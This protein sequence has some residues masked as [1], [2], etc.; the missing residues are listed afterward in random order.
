MKAEIFEFLIRLSLTWGALLAFYQWAFSGNDN[1]RLKRTFLLVVYL[2]GWMIPLLPTLYA[3]ST[4]PELT[5]RAGELVKMVGAASA[6]EVAQTGAYH[7]DIFKTIFTIYLTG[8]FW[9]SIK[10][11]MQYLRLLYWK[12]TGRQSTFRSFSVI[13]H[14]KIATP[15]A[16]LSTIFLPEKTDPSTI[17]M[18][19]LHE[20]VHL[21]SKH[22]IE[23]MPLILG[24]VFLWFHPLQWL[25]LR[26]QE[27]IQEYE[28][29]E[30][31]TREFSTV[32][33]GKLLIQSSMLSSTWHPKLFSSP[34]K[35]R[36]HMMTKQKN[37]KRLNKS[38]YLIFFALLGFLL[39]NCSD[40]V[41]QVDLTETTELS[42]TEVDQ[43]PV[44]QLA[45]A[46]EGET[47]PERILL[48]NIYREITYPASARSAGVGGTYKATF[49]IDKT[50]KMQALKAEAIPKAEVDESLRI[51]VVGYGN[52]EK[53]NITAQSS[54]QLQSA[55]EREIERTLT[56][57]P[58]WNP[59]MHEGMAVPV[60]MN[61]F[62]EYKLE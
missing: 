30:E 28:V 4:L 36:I 11:L 2:M 13:R 48:E 43:A 18:I 27:E 37:R 7:L 5:L 14:E 23:R 45:S 26:L 12:K 25:F 35:K 47:S 15:F 52:T 33:Y 58:D 51:V 24:Q 61:L 60:T 62:F 59:A 41:E 46:K 21:K 54:S 10:L 22:P 29:D 39:V 19:C 3:G 57:L 38:H 9:H 56:T 20:S 31:V 49:T 6:G 17:E 8:V 44:L 42:I 55:L 16:A 34:L 50:G 1:W 53:Q 40:L 32:S